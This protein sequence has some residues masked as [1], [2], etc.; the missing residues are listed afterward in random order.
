MT[1]IRISASLE[2]KL[3]LGDGE[4]MT[5][6]AAMDGRVG[7][8][9]SPDEAQDRLFNL[10]RHALRRDVEAL[11]EFTPKYVRAK[12]LRTLGFDQVR[13]AADPNQRMVASRMDDSGY[14]W[15]DG[16]PEPEPDDEDES[17]EARGV[18]EVGASDLPEGDYSDMQP[19]DFGL[20]FLN[21]PP[22]GD[23]G[24]IPF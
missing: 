10:L 5:I 11:T 21:P 1:K 15:N 12:L 6:S 18:V 24:V 19:D 9:E 14:G 4:F 22:A 3:S 13:R 2:A 7:K 20:L 23:G 16:D 17:T 8:D